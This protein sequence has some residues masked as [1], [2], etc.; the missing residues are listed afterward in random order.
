MADFPQIDFEHAPYYKQGQFWLAPLNFDPDC[1]KGLPASA[2]IHDVTLRDGEQLPGVTFT[3]DERVR[4]AECLADLGVYRMEAG[5]PAVSDIQFKALKRI[6]HAGYKTKVFAF[7]RAMAKDIQLS[8]DAGVEGVVVEHCVNPYTCK[9]AYGLTP[10]KLI[11]RLVDSFK[12]V[13]DAGLYCTF[14]G[15]DWFRTPVEWSK[16]IVEECLNEVEFDGLA[17]VDTYGS[18]TP[19]AVEKMVRLF[20]TWFP[21]LSLEFHGHNDMGWGQF[22]GLS[23]LRGGAD[24]IHTA[25]NSLGERAGNVPTEELAVTAQMLYGVDFGVN[26]DRIYPNCEVIS[27]ISQMPIGLQ[28]PILGERLYQ[29][30]NGV[31][32]HIAAKIGDLGVNPVLFSIMPDVIGKP[33]GTSILLGKNSGKNTIVLELKKLGLPEASDSELQKLL[34]LVKAEGIVTKSLV[35]DSQ[36][37]SIYKKVMD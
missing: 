37:L 10:E 25:M 13:K 2:K 31:N 6:A 36:F 7:T 20:K 26:L 21:Q 3:E 12:M 17:V 4:I 16:W 1:R 33:G 32:T 18:A 14:M 34:D 5:M 28:K 24:V 23:A 35:S 27:K 29:V 19:D 9:Y 8:I 30:E 11:K 15:W 22:A